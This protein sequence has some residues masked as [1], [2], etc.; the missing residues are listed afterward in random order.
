[1]SE[2]RIDLNDTPKALIAAAKHLM[3]LAGVDKT[4]QDAVVDGPAD[5]S[6]LDPAPDNTQAPDSTKTQADELLDSAGMPWDERIHSGGV[7]RLKKDGTWKQRRG[8]DKELVKKIEAEIRAGLIPPGPSTAEPDPATIFGQ[9]QGATGNAPV[10]TPV[11][12][13]QVLWP[14][15]LQRI[16][17]ATREGRL[18]GNKLN[19][20]LVSQGITGGTPMLAT[21]PDLYGWLIQE[22][23]L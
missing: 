8:V 19:Q 9:Q 12:P 18:D 14:E 21:R 23:G 20:M 5:T 15:M 16:T 7:D 11:D 22:L 2:L 3:M 13:N 4:P 10:G 6:A 1:M 17:Q